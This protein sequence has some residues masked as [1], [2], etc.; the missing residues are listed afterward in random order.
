MTCWEGEQFPLTS[1]RQ[2]ITGYVENA[3]TGEAN[4]IE[5]VTKHRVH[6]KVYRSIYNVI[7]HTVRRYLAAMQNTSITA[8]SGE[9]QT[10]KQ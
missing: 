8:H 1:V 3:K 6:V 5:V 7:Y 4:E 2:I 9:V 10:T